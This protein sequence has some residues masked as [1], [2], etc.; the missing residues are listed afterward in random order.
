M[1]KLDSIAISPKFMLLVGTDDSCPSRCSWS[2]RTPAA[3]GRAPAVLRR[4]GTVEAGWNPFVGGYGR[5]RMHKRTGMCPIFGTLRWARQWATAANVCGTGSCTIAAMCRERTC[6]LLFP[7][8]RWADSVHGRES[9]VS[10]NPWQKPPNPPSARDPRSPRD[11]GAWGGK[12]GP[13]EIH[14]VIVPGSLG[15]LE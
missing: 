10:P 12:E 15:C 14:V 13:S 5:G 3:N 2:P 4:L 11:P 1:V 8:R 7:C 6:S 9:R